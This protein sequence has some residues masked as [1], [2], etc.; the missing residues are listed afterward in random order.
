MEKIYTPIL[1]VSS[2]D[3]FSSVLSCANRLTENKT[4]KIA[5]NILNVVFFR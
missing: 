2:G 4:M 3:G 1:A 5:A